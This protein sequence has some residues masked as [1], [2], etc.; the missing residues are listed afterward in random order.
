[1]DQPV[2]EGQPL[3]SFDLHALLLSR[4]DTPWYP[5]MQLFRQHTLGDWEDMFDR[6]AQKATPLIDTRAC[7]D[8]PHSDRQG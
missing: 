3:P 7:Q 2:I 4:D 5:T 6:M 8:E 1:M